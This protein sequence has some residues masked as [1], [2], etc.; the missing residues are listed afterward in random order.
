MPRSL[1]VTRTVT[2]GEDRCSRIDKNTSKLLKRLERVKGIEP[3][4]SAWKSPD[5]RNVFKSRS[6]ISQLFG[7]LRSL[8]NFSLSEWRLLP[9]RLSGSEFGRPAVRV[10]WAVDGTGAG[11]SRNSQ[12][13]LMGLYE[14]E[15]TV[16]FEVGVR[17][18]ARVHGRAETLLGVP[19]VDPAGLQPVI[20]CRFVIVEHALGGAQ[21]VYENLL[22][23]V[24]NKV[25]MNV[26]GRYVNQHGDY[27]YSKHYARYGY[28]E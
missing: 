7:R 12:L 8:R 23:V 15:H 14:F 2:P 6:D 5:F 22:G 1:F 25:D 10:Q 3:S 28:T 17:H 16:E 11:G 9:K 24:L 21:G 20:V 4:Y 18:L 19:P 27:Y 13:L 26:F